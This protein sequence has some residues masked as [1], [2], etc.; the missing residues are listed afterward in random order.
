MEALPILKHR[1]VQVYDQ[2]TFR[3]IEDLLIVEEHLK[4]ILNGQELV[5]MACSPEYTRE[6]AIGYLVSE[7]MLRNYQ[8][9][10]S[11][12]AGHPLLIEVQTSGEQGDRPPVSLINTCMGRG[13]GLPVQPLAFD[14]DHKSWDPSHLLQLIEELDAASLTFK[15][16]GGVHSAALADHNGTLVR[17]EDIGRHNAVDKVIGHAF[18]KQIPLYDKCLLLS[19]RIAS[20]ILLKLARIG[21]PMV[22][23]RSAPT[24]K[25]V[26]TADELGITVVGFARGQ[27]FNLYTHGERIVG[28]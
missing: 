21:I 22:V 9:L 19:G 28:N 4:I 11:L 1:A 24:L 16:T 17:Y 14:N 26:Q 10:Y 7:G 2:G 8:D 3:T 27:R 12:Q 20:E 25:T 5:T 23:S 13:S 15:R 18:L 6:L